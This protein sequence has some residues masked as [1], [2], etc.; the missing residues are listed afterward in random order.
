MDNFYCAAIHKNLHIDGSNAYGVRLRPC[1]NYIPTKI[2]PT[3]AEYAN[4]DEFKSLEQAS[5]WPVG[6]GF[7]KKAESHDQISP[8]MLINQSLKDID[9]VRYELFPSNICNLKCMMCDP[10]LS[11]AL[12]TEQYKLNIVDKIYL[13][14]YDQ[15]NEMLSIVET[16]PK[17]ESISVIG[18]EFFLTK[19]NLEAM[20]YAIVNN[21][22]LRIVTNA[23]VLLD[24]HL[25]KLKQIPKLEL[26]ISCDGIETGYEFMRYPAKWDLFKANSQ[27]IISE[28][29]GQS[30]N[31]N[32]VLQVLN[33]MYLIP[34]LDYFNKLKTKV[35]ITM[36]NEPKW[37]SFS[38]LSNEEKSTLKELLDNQLSVYKLSR[39]Q[40][41]IVNKLMLH[42]DTITTNTTVRDYSIERL[43]KTYKLRK[44]SKDIIQNQLGVYA[45]LSNK[46]ASP[47][48]VGDK[49]IS[50]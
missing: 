1:C 22:P 44:L 5:D 3:Y 16:G 41:D 46:L 36:L 43:S 24:A 39:P 47:E 38:I 11:T 40:V 15:F 12:A 8:R 2:Y 14:E 6:C 7:C 10:K 31:V 25:E 45:E 20:D 34:T 9:G 17:A 27:R 50:L 42:L 33:A 18:G 4:S 32:F 48:V 21:L 49:I 23:T 37:L 35:R 30:I 29:A 19:N 13:K 28:L 26:Q